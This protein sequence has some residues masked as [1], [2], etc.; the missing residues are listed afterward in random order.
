MPEPLWQGAVIGAASGAALGGFAQ[1]MGEVA[2]MCGLGAAL[3]GSPPPDCGSHVPRSMLIGAGIGAV[4]GAGLDALMW[5]RTTVFAT[6]EAG[7]G[8]R[9]GLSP[10]ADRR[11]VGLR[12]MVDF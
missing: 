4:I 11:R 7:T 10:I 2:D 12:V 9:V 5:K 1:A 3:S 6:P 8:T